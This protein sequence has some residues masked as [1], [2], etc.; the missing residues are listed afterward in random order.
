LKGAIAFC[1]PGP[2]FDGS[3]ILF[4][5]IVEILALAQTNSAGESALGFQ[6]FRCSRIGRVGGF[7]ST[8]K[9]GGM[10]LE[11]ELNTFSLK[12]LAAAV[13]RFAVSRK[14]IVCPVESTAR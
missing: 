9:T 6:G 7:L 8:L 2:L 13:S 5:N 12:R 1:Q 3:M 4:N 14:S 10:G 11:E